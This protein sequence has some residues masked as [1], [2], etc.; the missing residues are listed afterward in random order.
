MASDIAIA[1]KDYDVRGG[2]EILAETLADGLDAPL[3]VGHSSPGNLPDLLDVDVREIGAG[4]KWHWLAG[5][6]GLPRA[7]A[8]M[9]LWRDHAPDALDGHD[10]VVTSGNEPQWWMPREEQTW[11]AYTHSTPRWMY[12]LY[13]DID[14]WVG[15]TATQ[16]K[17]WIY[18]QDMSAGPDL[19]VAN[20]D[21]VARRMQRYW[22][23][24]DA[25]LRV[26]Y[27]PVET[28]RLGPDHAGTDD[29]YLALGR[30]AEVKGLREIVRTANAEGLPLKV[31][32]DGP[33]SGELRDLAGPTVEMYSWVDGQ[34]KR[35][36]LAGAKAL[37][38]NSR[39]EDFGMVPVEAIASGTPVLTVAEG[40]PQHTVLE[41]E[42]GQTFER[43][44]LAAA[45]TEFEREGIAWGPERMAAWA[46][47]HFSIPRFIDEMRDAIA[48]AEE[49]TTV[50][51]NL[52]E[53]DTTARIAADGGDD[54]V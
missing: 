4:S 3:Y 48:T 8:H 43:G 9:M 28:G 27:P 13:N 35:E 50:K 11:V 49:R 14:G 38:N 26:V 47:E 29:Y 25:D 7:V 34:R 16:V 23:L 45:I 41:P 20:S 12:D 21:V 40:M 31:V 17:R 36:L 6:S 1:H 2:G 24:S 46:H 54:G 30:L 18:E 51:P 52:R 42:C 53:P 15:R 19:W 5:R 22:G 39:N 44:D 33:L 37:I 32:G 10:V